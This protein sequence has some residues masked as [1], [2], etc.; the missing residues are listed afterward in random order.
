[1]DAV[2]AELPPERSRL[3]ALAAEF[4]RGAGL[5]ARLH[6]QLA[7]LHAVVAASLGSLISTSLAPRSSSTLAPAHGGGG[8]GG[9]GAVGLWQDAFGFAQVAVGVSART[10]CLYG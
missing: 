8:G 1:D 2:L 5:L 10:R 9:G 7:S 4:A 6:A 3:H